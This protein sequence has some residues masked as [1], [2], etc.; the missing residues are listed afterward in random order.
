MEFGFVGFFFGDDATIG[1]DAV[2]GHLVFPMK[3]MVLFP[4]GMQ[5]PTP[6]AKRPKSLAKARIQTS[7]FGP[8]M[9]LWY[10]WDSPV[11]GLMTALAR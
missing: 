3:K 8:L 6:W 10:S 5:V 4:F 1:D 7:R 9:S 11:M 2:C